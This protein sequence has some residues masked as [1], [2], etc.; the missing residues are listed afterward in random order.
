MDSDLHT[1]TFKEDE[2]DED[3]DSIDHTDSLARPDNARRTDT[4]DAQHGR[5]QHFTTSS[6]GSDSNLTSAFGRVGRSEVDDDAVLLGTAKL[7]TFNF[8]DTMDVRIFQIFSMS[9]LS[10]HIIVL[11]LLSVVVVVVVVE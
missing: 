3:D 4:S 10:I 7:A 8:V 11:L 9:M 5:A 1:D 2:D 6:S